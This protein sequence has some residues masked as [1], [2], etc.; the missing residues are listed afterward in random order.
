MPEYDF[1]C[2]GCGRRTALRWRSVAEYAAATPVCPNCG[3]A[4]LTRLISAVGVARPGRDYAAMSAGEML[5]VLEGEDAG[6]VRELQRQVY[7]GGE[8]E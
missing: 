2:E 3:S 1:R 5:G 4:A 7:G 6:E 8:A